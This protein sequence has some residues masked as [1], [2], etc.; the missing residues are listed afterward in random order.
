MTAQG[1]AEAQRVIRNH[2]LWELYLITFA[3]IAPSHVD[4]DA[5]LIEHVLD[6]DI[7]QQLE[8]KL[9]AKVLDVT[10]PPSPH[11]VEQPK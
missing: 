7:I 9:S 4:R 5:D 3:D 1:L 10:P 6:A 8:A 11:V 2:R